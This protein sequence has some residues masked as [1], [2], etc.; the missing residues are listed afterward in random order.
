MSIFAVIT[1]DLVK[2]SSYQSDDYDQLLYLLDQ[3][4]RSVSAPQGYN[5][6]RGD[7]FQLLLNEPEQVV[8]VA[9]VL[10]L[11]LIAA[12]SDAR[13]CMAIATA[14]NLRAD[15][16]TAT[17]PVFTLSGTG[18][19]RLQ[20]QRWSLYCADGS[21][22]LDLLLR[23]ADSQLLQLTAR[24][25]QVLLLYLLASD[26]SHQALAATLNTSRANVTALLNQANYA[27]FSDFLAHCQLWV[28]QYVQ[29]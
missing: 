24:Q 16:K 11:N 8:S 15:I 1:G 2:S 9:L 13:L 5:I 6:Y 14:D 21:Q 4:L 27:L 22:P 7:A 10:R 20:Q 19:D 25:A 18:L 12:R 26:K 3:S 23:F 28:H 29:S 17:G